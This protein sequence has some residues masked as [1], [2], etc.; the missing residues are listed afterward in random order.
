MAADGLEV[1]G[2]T[3]YITSALIASNMKSVFESYRVLALEYFALEN[4]TKFLEQLSKNKKILGNKH[5]PLYKDIQRGKYTFIWRSTMYHKL[6][7]LDIKILLKSID[8]DLLKNNVQPNAELTKMRFRIYD[9]IDDLEGN[10]ACIEFNLFNKDWPLASMKWNRNSLI[11][12]IWEWWTIS[13]Q[14]L[15]KWN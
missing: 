12:S 1:T 10:D 11:V 13:S 2:P 4:I 6:I 7:F 5:N 14:L 3:D 8:E 9:K 15:S